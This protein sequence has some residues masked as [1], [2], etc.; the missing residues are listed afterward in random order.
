MPS[1]RQI[2]RILKLSDLPTELLQII[3][4][5]YVNSTKDL[6]RLGCVC[7]FWRNAVF[8][9]PLWREPNVK[10]FTFYF[11]CSWDQSYDEISPYVSPHEISRWYL[12]RLHKCLS[13]SDEIAN[14]HAF[15]TILCGLLVLITA[16]SFGINWHHPDIVFRMYHVGFLSLSILIFLT[17]IYLS[18]LVKFRSKTPSPFHRYLLFVSCLHFTLLFTY[19]KLLFHSTTLWMIIITPPC[20]LMLLEIIVTIKHECDRVTCRDNFIIKLGFGA[21]ASLLFFVVF[22]PPWISL[23]LYCYYLDYYSLFHVYPFEYSQ[24]FMPISLHILFAFGYLTQYFIKN[25]GDRAVLT[26]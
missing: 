21:L 13:R 11:T 4:S 24:C 25:D 8:N 7:Q 23:Y 14:F 16:L 26:N 18:N 5:Y 19:H 22:M 15:L 10:K 20:V 3:I 6:I 9:S 1:S 2:Q 17:P 12:T